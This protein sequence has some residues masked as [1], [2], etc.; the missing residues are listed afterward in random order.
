MW[1]VFNS[2]C[3]LQQVILLNTLSMLFDIEQKWAAQQLQA[4]W[5]LQE[6][7]DIVSLA[8]FQVGWKFTDK[9]RRS[10]WEHWICVYQEVRWLWTTGACCIISLSHILQIA[11]VGVELDCELHKKDINKLR[12]KMHRMQLKKHTTTAFHLF[13]LLFNFLKFGNIHENEPLF[14]T[15]RLFCYQTINWERFTQHLWISPGMQ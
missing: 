7:I 3:V 15:G 4:V 13:A 12:Q 6:H 14:Q 10:S 11:L 8:K 2:E 1:Y 9:N 5:R